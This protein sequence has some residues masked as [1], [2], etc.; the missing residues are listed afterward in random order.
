MGTFFEFNKF[1]SE[2]EVNDIINQNHLFNHYFILRRGLIDYG[3][4]KRTKNGAKYWKGDFIYNQLETEHLIIRNSEEEDVDELIKIFLNNAY[5][6]Q[7]T[8]F[9][10]EEEYIY[11]LLKEGDP[12]PNG[13]VEFYY[14]KSILKKD[15]AKVIGFLEYYQGYPDPHTLWISSLFLDSDYKQK[16]YGSEVTDT[17]C[18]DAFNGYF[19]RAGVGVHLKNWQALHFW[20]KKGF[21]EIHSIHGDKILSDQTYSIIGLM[22]NKY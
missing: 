20:F 17:L 19:N 14:L 15:T 1:Y 10:H 3:I 8:G 12:P 5:V 11:K 22:K 13:H 16:G 6:A 9:K 7:Y 2:A 21:K 4:L 18:K